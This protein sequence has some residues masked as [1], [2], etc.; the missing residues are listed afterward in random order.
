M[1]A[2]PV[3]D[4]VIRSILGQ[5]LDEDS[6]IINRLYWSYTGSTSA[7]TLNAFALDIATCWTAQIEGFMGVNHALRSIECVDLSSDAAP[8]GAWAGDNAGGAGVNS[9]PAAITMVVKHLIQ[10]RYR[11]GKPKTFLSGVNGNWS[12]DAQSWGADDV[13]S[14]ESSWGVFITDTIAGAPDSL[15]AVNLVNVSYYQGF[16]S[17]ENP[18]TGRWR[19]IPSLRAV[20]VVDPIV[21]H[22]IDAKFGSQRRRSLLHS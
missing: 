1:P 13:A 19:T 9:V 11:G 4:G 17:V 22:V 15:G 14:A 10:R 3:V 2:L 6:N 18:I 16:T 20:P 5:S 8:V 21:A 12:H 7:T